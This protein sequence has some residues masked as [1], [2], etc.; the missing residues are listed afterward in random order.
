MVH[1]T[2]DNRGRK[3]KVRGAMK[4]KKVKRHTKSF[5]EK[6]KAKEKTQ[7]RYETEHRKEEKRG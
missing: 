3:R 1:S 7:R 2:A 5:P 6:R 4:R